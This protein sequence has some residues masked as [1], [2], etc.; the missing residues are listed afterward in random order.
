M[1]NRIQYDQPSIIGVLETLR[2]IFDDARLVDATLTTQYEPDGSGSYTASPYRC[3]AIWNKAHRCENCISAKA[4]AARSRITKYE[5]IGSDV[6][7]IVAKYVEVDSRP[8]VLEI[9]SRVTDEI[10]FGACGRERF[11]QK[12]ES[13]NRM[14]YRDPL[15][16][17]YNRGYYTEQMARISGQLGFAMMDVDHFKQVNDTYGHEA[18]DKVLCAVV[19]ILTRSLALSDTVIRFGGDEFVFLTHGVTQEVLSAR[20]TGILQEIRALRL[21]D[22]P[23]LQVTASVGAVWAEH[24]EQIPDILSLADRRLYLAKARRDTFVLGGPTV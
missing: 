19:A 10:L 6:Y 23:G 11:I 13:Y 24:A 8:F 18:G 20:I 16:G 1:G 22:F 9:V 2:N 21:A 4:L 14:L 5:F 17:A 15:T 3:Y 7:Y 12:I